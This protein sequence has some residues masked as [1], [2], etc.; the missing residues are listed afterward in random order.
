MLVLNEKKEGY[1]I[2]W[3]VE[4]EGRRHPLSILH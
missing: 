4:I 1:L 3:R 2:G